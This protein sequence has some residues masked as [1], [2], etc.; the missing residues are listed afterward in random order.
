MTAPPLPRVDP[1]VVEATVTLRFAFD[2]DWW[3]ESG[4]RAHYW[5]PATSAE[6]ELDAPAF[7]VLVAERVGA[8]YV[9]PTG[10]VPRCEYHGRAGCL[11][12]GCGPQ[13]DSSWVGSPSFFDAPQ[14]VVGASRRG[15]EAA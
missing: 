14:I 2:G 6:R 15:G 13:D 8:V 9:P 3:V 11:H 12:P 10:G 4:D 7:A 1:A 5:I